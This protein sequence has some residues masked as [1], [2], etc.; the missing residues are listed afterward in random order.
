MNLC[1]IKKMNDNWLNFKAK[2]QHKANQK[3]N[4]A[5]NHEMHTIFDCQK[6]MKHTEQKYMLIIYIHIH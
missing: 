5:C 1:K 6:K 2:P 3:K 4:V